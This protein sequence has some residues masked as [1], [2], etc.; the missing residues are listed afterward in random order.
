MNKILTEREGGILRIR[1][2]RAEK[3][4]AITAS[5]YQALAH[6]L[7]DAERDN[8]VQVA[9]LHGAPDAFT[10]GNDLQDFLAS[11]PRSN[12]A[13]GFQFLRAIHDFP[14]P[15]IAAVS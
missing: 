2:N 12:D 3:K 15:L 11:P 1:F 14:K 10:A 9:L 4:N 7:R 13:P 5:M 8:A 6:A